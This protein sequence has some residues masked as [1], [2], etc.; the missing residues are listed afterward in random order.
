MFLNCKYTR[1]YYSL[2]DRAKTR[3]LKSEI[4]KHHII[5]RSL[6]GG[7]EKENLVSLTPREHFICHRFLAKMTTG[8]AKRSMTCAI[9]YM[10]NFRQDKISS[11]TY[12]YIK[13]QFSLMRTGYRHSEASKEQM[14][15]THKARGITPEN[16]IKMSKAKIGMKFTQTHCQNIS[17][18]QRGKTLTPEHRENL[19]RGCMNRSPNNVRQISIDGII[20]SS[21]TEASRKLN[22]HNTTLAHRAKSPTFPNTF[23]V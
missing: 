2:I 3:Q 22:I 8:P 13:K 21:T 18:A 17:N 7:N 12:A 9:M 10:S 6:G 4:E 1:W 19:K 11:R 15:L 16:R 20:Y 14:S 5:P 23:F